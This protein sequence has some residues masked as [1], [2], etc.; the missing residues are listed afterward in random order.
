MA[1]R[2]ILPGEHLGPWNHRLSSFYRQP[3]SGPICFTGD[4]SVDMRE[5]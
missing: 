4:I 1:D 5:A 2:D 3:F